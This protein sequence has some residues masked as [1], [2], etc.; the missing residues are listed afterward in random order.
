MILEIKSGGRS[1]S[2]RPQLLSVSAKFCNDT[3]SDAPFLVIQVVKT[4]I[5]SCVRGKTG[6]LAIHHQA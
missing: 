5:T 6:T 2:T 4:G 1:L 3:A